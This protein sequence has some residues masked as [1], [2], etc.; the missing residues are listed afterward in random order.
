MPRPTIRPLS[1]ALLLG[2]PALFW[3][4]GCADQ[5]PSAP[6]NEDLRLAAVAES[7]PSFGPFPGGTTIFVDVA[8]TTDVQD[9]SRAHPF[10]TLRRGLAAA[11]SNSVVGMAAG[12]YADEFG[13][14]LSPNYVIDGLSNFRLLGSGAQ[15]TIIRGNH[16][17]SLI[18]VVHGSTVLSRGVTIEKGGDPTHSVGGGIQAFGAA[19]NLTIHLALA[20]VILRHNTAVSGGALA[21]DGNVVLHVGNVVAAENVGTRGPGAFYLNGINGRITSMFVNTTITRNTSSA[22]FGGVH[23]LFTARLDAANVVLWNNAPTEITTAP[24]GQT[25]LVRFS[26]IAGRLPRIREPLGRSGLR[27][28]GGGQLSSLSY[29]TPDRRGRLDT[30]T[31]QRRDRQAT[32]GGRRS[33]LHS[34]SRHGGLRVRSAKHTVLE[35]RGTRR[36]PGVGRCTLHSPGP[37]S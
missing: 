3:L 36:R 35:L 32:A 16:S 10:H 33:R 26:D 23:L 28:S 14:E 27:E 37:L 12:V 11:K 13:P 34:R 1:L 29:L 4:T 20:N 30:V 19:D 6:G 24:G 8:N 31:G 7:G 25:V 9:G 22:G 21:A 18:R 15:R 2:V 17:F 5:M